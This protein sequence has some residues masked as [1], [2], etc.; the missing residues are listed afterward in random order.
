MVRSRARKRFADSGLSYNDIFDHKEIINNEIQKELDKHSVNGGLRM[1]LHK[2][3]AYR[4]IKETRNIECYFI[5]VNGPY[6]KK[7]EAV[8]CNPE[9]FVGFAGWASDGN[10]APFVNGFCTALDAIKT[11][12][13]EGKPVSEKL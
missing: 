3:N 12:K 5:F 13:A 9:G 6:F 4:F 1:V 8:S 7:R 11:V 10:V 2:K